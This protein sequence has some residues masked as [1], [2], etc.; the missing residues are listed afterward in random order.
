MDIKQINE[1]TAVGGQIMA[2]EV[3]EIA[4]AGFRS[5]ICNRP[6]GEGA[7]QLFFADIEKAA[8]LAGLKSRY[9]PIVSCKVRD[10]DAAEFGKALNELPKPVFAYCRTGMRSAAL[11]SQ[12]AAAK[13]GALPDILSST[14]AAGFD[15]SGVVRRIASGGKEWM[16]KPEI[17]G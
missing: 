9:I 8:E 6:D 17:V 3:M 11:W 10:E 14:K 4:A 12:Q 7:D 5:I 13:G 16:A 1:K 2:S 15:M